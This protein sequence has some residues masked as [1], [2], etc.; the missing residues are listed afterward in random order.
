[1]SDVYKTMCPMCGNEFAPLRLAQHF[2]SWWCERKHRRR[3]HANAMKRR[4]DRISN[5]PNADLG[6]RNPVSWARC[7]EPDNVPSVRRLDC[8][9]YDRCLAHAEIRNWSGF[10]C[11]YCGEYEPRASVETP[12]AFYASTNHRLSMAPDNRDAIELATILRNRKRAA[13]RDGQ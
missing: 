6:D 4:K 1:V 13:R 8:R 2:C 11:N 12:S 10:T 3:N 7:I 5:A 9:S